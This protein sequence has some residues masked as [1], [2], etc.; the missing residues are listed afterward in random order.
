MSTGTGVWQ[1]VPLDHIEAQELLGRRLGYTHVL[2]VDSTILLQDPRDTQEDRLKRI[3][4]PKTKPG[5]R[6]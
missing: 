4:E 6:A 5:V 1:V 2:L 3:V